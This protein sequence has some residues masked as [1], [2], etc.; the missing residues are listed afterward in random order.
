M[1]I[2]ECLPFAHD[3]TSA[4]VTPQ[5]GLLVDGQVGASSFRC[6]LAAHT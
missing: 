1:S 2:C 5:V 6:D 3:S 4:V